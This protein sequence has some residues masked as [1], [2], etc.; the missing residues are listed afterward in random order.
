M[1]NFMYTAGK[2]LFVL[3]GFTLFAH[4]RFMPTHLKTYMNPRP[5]L[6]NGTGISQPINFDT[7]EFL[8]ENPEIDEKPEITEKPTI[9]SNA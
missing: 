4:S 8:H 3:T 6:K 5:I 1:N 9:V 2:G 7:Y